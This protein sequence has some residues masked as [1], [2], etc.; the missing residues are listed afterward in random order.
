MNINVHNKL[1]MPTFTRSKDMIKAQFFNGSHDPY[2]AY[3]G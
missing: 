1:E 2:H 3:Y